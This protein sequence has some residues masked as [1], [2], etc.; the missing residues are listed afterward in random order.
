MAMIVITHCALDRK[1]LGLG[2]SWVA[3]RSYR[4]A[5]A[6]PF[7]V[8]VLR[9]RTSEIFLELVSALYSQKCLGEHNRN[10]IGRSWLL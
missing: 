7:H 8:T 10:G 3:T 5:L 9:P 6:L 1:N 2:F 4:T